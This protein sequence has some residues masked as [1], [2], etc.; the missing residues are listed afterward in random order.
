VGDQRKTSLRLLPCVFAA[1]SVPSIRHFQKH[2]L[3]ER[4]RHRSDLEIDLLATVVL[5]EGLADQ[6]GNHPE[7]GGARGA[8][9]RIIQ[10]L[11]VDR[12]RV[13]L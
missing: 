5:S 9:W 2:W 8:G 11:A 10:I 3:L 4:N 6:I 13:I 12:I 7:A 1:G